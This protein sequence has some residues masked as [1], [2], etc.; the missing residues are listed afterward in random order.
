[1]STFEDSYK[2]QLLGVS[3]QIPRERVDGQVSAQ[4]NML[5]D[6]VTGLRRRLGMPWLAAIGTVASS[7]GDN[8]CLWRTSVGSQVLH[9]MLDTTNGHLTTLNASYGIVR[10]DV[11]PYLIAADTSYIRTA[12]VG[13]AFY[14]CNTTTTPAVGSPV[15][16]P[17]FTSMGY[18]YV[19]ASAPDTWYIVRTSTSLSPT[20]TTHGAYSPALPASSPEA[21]VTTLVSSINAGTGTHGIIATQ[22]GQYCFLHCAVATGLSVVTGAAIGFPADGSVSQVQGS[23][24]LM[25]SGKNYVRNS[26]DLPSML[27]VNANGYLVATGDVA[28]PVYYRYSS[29]TQQWLESGSVDSPATLTGMPIALEEDAFGSIALVSGVFDGRFAG[30][31][32]TNPNPAFLKSGITGMGSY[33]GRLVLLAGALVYMS[34]SGQPRQFY[35]STITSL[36]DSDPIGVGAAKASSAKWVHA[37]E[38][39]HDLLVFASDFQGVVLGSNTAVTPRTAN[40]AV[41]S[42]YTADVRTAPIA[43]N[44]SLL[45]PVRRSQNFFG[46]MELSRSKLLADRFDANDV[47]AHVPKYMAGQCIGAATSDTADMALFRASGDRQ[48]LIVCEFVGP[49]DQKQQSWHKWTFPYE[50]VAVFFAGGLLRVALRRA[51]GVSLMGVDV[52]GGVTNA[53]GYHTG[54]LDMSSVV[55]VVGNVV[56]TPSFWPESAYASLQAVVADGALAGEEVGL[57]VDGASIRTVRSFPDGLISIGGVFTSV[58]SPTQPMRRDWTGVKISSNKMTVLRFMLGVSGTGAFTATVGDAMLDPEAIEETA[59]SFSSS[60]LELDRALAADNIVNI[61]ARTD[62]NTTSL[63][64]STNGVHDLNVVSLE[65]VARFHQKIHRTRGAA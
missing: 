65:F 49:K 6:P 53:A 59:V 56:A 3:Q 30:D 62:A 21:I 60:E 35:R 40:V 15:I 44:R 12:E 42:N 26:A 8:V 29:A 54:K 58:Y 55:P 32:F 47:T 28:R 36:L 51:T 27:P 45:F 37:V 13:G 19:A 38:S 20:Y 5:S 63:V 17:A 57:V 64:V 31:G 11:V 18:F 39:D 4:D 46:L 10:T 9:V 1:M 14:M 24:Q 23:H 16:G 48:S 43:V 2:P 41:I 25:V 61:P 7:S 22:E 52:R 34:A 50:V 33:Q